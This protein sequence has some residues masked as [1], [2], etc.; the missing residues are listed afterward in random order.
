M[1]IKVWFKTKFHEVVS[2]E[3]SSHTDIVPRVLN[4]PKHRDRDLSQDYTMILSVDDEVWIEQTKRFGV[5][6]VKKFIKSSLQ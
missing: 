5:L 4:H 3:A 6:E 2:I 1:I